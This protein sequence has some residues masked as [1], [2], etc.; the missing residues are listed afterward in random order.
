MCFSATASFIA[1]GSLGAIGAGS[2]LVAKKRFKK[3]RLF[4]SIPFIFAIQ[5]AFEG[6]LWLSIANGG[7]SQFF[8]YGFLFFAFF[9]WPGFIPFSL[10]LLEENKGKKWLLFWA[11]IVGTTLGASLFVIALVSGVDLT[12]MEESLRYTMDVAGLG[13]VLTAVYVLIVVG[14][15]FVSSNKLIKSFGALVGMAVVFSYAFYKFAF[16]SV[17]CFFAAVLSSYILYISWKGKK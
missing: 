3:G 15:C 13:V 4:A 5:Q 2:N 8:L 11:T 7:V 14:S 6:L 9:L 1:S 16:I 12:V 10:Y 17:W